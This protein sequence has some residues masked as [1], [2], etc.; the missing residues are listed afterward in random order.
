M[1]PWTRRRAMQAR[2]TVR[3]GAKHA[4]DT[5]DDAGGIGHPG[6]RD[7]VE[8]SPAAVAMFIRWDSGD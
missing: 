2:M 1:D 4:A 6:Q 3:S 8:L 7:K 5:D